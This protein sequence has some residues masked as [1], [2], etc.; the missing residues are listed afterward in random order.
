[1]KKLTVA[2]TQLHVVERGNGPPLL[3]V[4]GFPLD[5]QMWHGQIEAFS[6]DFRVIAPDLRGFGD[7]EANLEDVSMA[8]F[9]DDLASLL[10]VLLVDQPV[11]FCGLSMGG[12]VAWQFW[13]RHRPR[14]DKLILCDTRAAADSREAAEARRETAER[15]LEQGTGM[16]VDTM[17]PKLFSTKTR[18][19]NPAI[20]DATATVIRNANARG[21]AAALRG[22]AGRPDVTSWLPDVQVPTLVICGQHDAISAVSEMQ[23]LADQLPEATFVV[24]PECG[25][26]A[27]LEDPEYVNQALRTFLQG[28]SNSD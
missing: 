8:T 25:H 15:V 28:S 11:S 24:I 9:A 17:I 19:T 7:S 4:H 16:L 26:M 13:K 23:T 14:L 21:V 27:P 5:H 1:M 6:Q 12:Y 18:N 3:F 22:M 2:G 10:D 20:V